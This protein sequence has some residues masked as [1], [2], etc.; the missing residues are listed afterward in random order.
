MRQS[1]FLPSACA[2]AW[3]L[4][5][6]SALAAVGHRRFGRDGPAGDRAALI[7]FAERVPGGTPEK[8][9]GRRPARFQR[10]RANDHV[11]AEAK[12]SVWGNWIRPAAASAIP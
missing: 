1:L 3:S 8:P 12:I 7:E 6:F 9:A 5:I 4:C 11:T 10:P 2:A